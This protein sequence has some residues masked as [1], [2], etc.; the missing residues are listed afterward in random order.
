MLPTGCDTERGD[1]I[2]HGNNKYLARIKVTAASSRHTRRRARAATT[3]A[4]ERPPPVTVDRRVWRRAGR[5]RI[6]CAVNEVGNR[7]RFATVIINGPKVREPKPADYD[8][9]DGSGSY[10]LYY[11]R[12]ASA[13]AL[14]LQHRAV[15]GWLWSVWTTVSTSAVSG[16]SSRDG[17]GE[18]AV[19]E[20]L[21]FL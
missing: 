14:S 19:R 3:A 9:D 13:A 11:L 16:E 7:P 4:E 6:L 5:W 15:S 18:T 1:G 8:V 12:S 17:G 2:I 20:V 10:I 21:S